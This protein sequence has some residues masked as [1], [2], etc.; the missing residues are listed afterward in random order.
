MKAFKAILYV[1]TGLT[2]FIFGTYGAEMWMK[3]NIN[4]FLV[5][6]WILI[7]LTVLS[8]IFYAIHGKMK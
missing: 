2:V 8:W 1:L 6:L 7:I 5:F 3:T 4:R